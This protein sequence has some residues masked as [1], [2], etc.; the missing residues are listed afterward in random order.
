MSEIN[1]YAAVEYIRLRDIIR[2]ES[3]VGITPTTV[4][5]DALHA[6]EYR[7]DHAGKVTECTR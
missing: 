5:G 3:H 2:E 1:W 4:M 7:M 6:A